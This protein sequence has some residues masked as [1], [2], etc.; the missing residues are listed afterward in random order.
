MSNGDQSDIPLNALRKKHVGHIG[1]DGA[2]AFIQQSKHRAVQQT[3]SHSNSL[4]LSAGQSIDDVAVVDPASALDD[5]VDSDRPQHAVN[6][7]I[8]KLT[9]SPRVADLHR[10]WKGQ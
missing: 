4:N 2:A 6:V 8:I 7:L 9:A 10:E 1:T 3:A 5:I